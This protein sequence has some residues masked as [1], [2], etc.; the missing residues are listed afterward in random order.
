MT[1]GAGEPL[2]YRSHKAIASFRLHRPSTA[3][4]AGRPE[5]SHKPS[6]MRF[7]TVCSSTV[8]AACGVAP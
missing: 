6:T 5:M 1:E 4:E 2:I 7:S 3:A 8:G